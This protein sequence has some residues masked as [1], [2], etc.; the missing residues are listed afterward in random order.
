MSREPENDDPL[1]FDELAT[2]IAEPANK[3]AAE[4][5]NHRLHADEP[6][7]ARTNRQAVLKEERAFEIKQRISDE[8]K[9][10]AD[11]AAKTARLRKLRLAKEAEE[12]TAI[13]KRKPKQS[14]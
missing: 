5:Q 6:R 3:S 2:R 10:Q 11:T 7:V 12:R 14:S 8:A 1:E 4:E 13:P 9:R